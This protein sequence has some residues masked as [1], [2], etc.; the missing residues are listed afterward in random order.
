MLVKSS[1]ILIFVP[2]E[3]TVLLYMMWSVIGWQALVGASSIAVVVVYI[4]VL[5]GLCF[6]LQNK[7]TAITRKRLALIQE[8]ISG[9]RT[10]KMNAWETVFTERVKNLR[11]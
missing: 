6:T 4:N 11:R 10:V 7:T 1:V 8:I 9:I 5:S 3:V 2:F